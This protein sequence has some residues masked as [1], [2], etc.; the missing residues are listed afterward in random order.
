MGYRTPCD[1]Y[2]W[3][4]GV[5]YSVD[6]FVSKYTVEFIHHAFNVWQ[7]KSW[8][9]ISRRFKHKATPRHDAEAVDRLPIEGA[10][11]VIRCDISGVDNGGGYGGYISD[12]N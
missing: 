7:N 6:V 9:G 11:Y 1:R 8:S 10:V 4:C 2:T 3:D 5:G 12:P